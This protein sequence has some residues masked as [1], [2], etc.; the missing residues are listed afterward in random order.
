[1]RGKITAD[2][3]YTERTGVVAP[4]ILLP[5]GEDLTSFAV[6][7]CDQFTSEKEYWEKLRRETAGKRTALDLIL[8]E[9]YLS[10]DNS[11]AVARIHANMER[12]LEEGAFRSAGAGFVLTAR[13]TPYAPLRLGLVLAVDLDRYSYDKKSDALIRATEGTIVDRLPPRMDIRRNAPLEFPHIML[14]ADDARRTVIEPLY[15]SRDRLEK[16]YD[17]DLNMGGGHI[18]G[19]MVRDVAPVQEAL[20]LLAEESAKKYGAPFLFAVGDGNHSLAT[21]KRC[22]EELKPALSAAER[23][24][25]P[26]RYALAEVVNLYD[27]GLRF[28]PIHR[29]AEGVDCAAFLERWTAEGDSRAVLL[30]GGRR[31]E[32][33]LPSDIARAV[34]AADAYIRLSGGTRVD[35]VHGEDSLGKLVAETPGSA[36]ILLPAMDKSGLF[37]SVAA[38]GSL[39][40][41]T[42]SLGEAVEKRYYIEGKFIG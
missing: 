12:Y 42:F 20:A 3:R 18:S 23:A 5:A 7:A 24:V 32:V 35:Y 26:A 38:G 14:L 29:F 19:W 9:A 37:A 1:M 36:G 8:P 2:A 41:K 13:S 27:E 40:R 17:F 4:E 6:V 16:A 33:A 34:D 39:P 10:A 30:A 22:W 31:R 21:A 28:E 15:L 25:H 11:A